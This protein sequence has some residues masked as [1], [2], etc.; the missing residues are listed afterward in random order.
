MKRSHIVLFMTPVLAIMLCWG[1]VAEEKPWFDLENCAFCK[2]LSAEPGL[3]EHMCTEYHDLSNGVMAVTVIDKEYREAYHRAQKNMEKVAEEWNQTGKAPY[4]CGFCTA[5]GEF[6]FAGVR[7][8]PIHGELAEVLLMTSD[9][10]VMVEKLHAFGKRSTEEMAKL[11]G[12]GKVNGGK[13]DE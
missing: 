9:D 8:E 5:Y 11:K 2:Q 3:V 7:F 12:A 10:S 6:M 1:S 4:T 13:S